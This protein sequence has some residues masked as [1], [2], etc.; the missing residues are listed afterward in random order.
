MKYFT[1]TLIHVFLGVCVSSVWFALG[2]YIYRHRQVPRVRAL[3]VKAALMTVF[4]SVLCSVTGILSTSAFLLDVGTLQMVRLV[5]YFCEEFSFWGVMA[6]QF[7]HQVLLFSILFPDVL[8]VSSNKVFWIAQGVGLVV[9]CTML[10]IELPSELQ[11][12]SVWIRWIARLS[13][14]PFVILLWVYLAMKTF[15][16]IR[17]HPMANEH[18]NHLVQMK[19]VVGF[20]C[21]SLLG[22]VG[23][24][25]VWFLCYLFF[26]QA[27][28][29][30]YRSLLKLVMLWGGVVWYGWPYV[31]WNQETTSSTNENEVRMNR[32]LVSLYKRFTRDSTKETSVH[33]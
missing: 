10:F 31:T 33:L 30:V 9:G 7:S 15:Q 6:T 17:D 3:C 14:F 28:M 26:P 19:T 32:L 22:I 12:A 1:F 23:D 18:L 4:F 16:K 2:L 27:N 21:I 8:R 11:I 29:I 25:G 20:A 5:F 13:L 24:F